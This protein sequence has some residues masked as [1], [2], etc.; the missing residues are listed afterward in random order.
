METPT[1][2]KCPECGSTRVFHDGFRKAPLNALSNEPIQRYRCVD[3]SHRFSYSEQTSNNKLIPFDTSQQNNPC[4][5][6]DLLA[7][8]QK[9]KI[10]VEKERTPTENELKAWLEIEKFLVQLKNDG[11]KAGT[12]LNYRKTFKHLLKDGADLFDPESTKAALAKSTLRESTKK[13]VTGILGNWFEYNQ[14]SWRVPKYS[15]EHEVPYIPTEKELELL[16]AALGKKT[17]CFCQLLKDTGARC[18]EIAELDWLSIDWEQKKVRIKAEKGSNSRIRPLS[19]KTIEML[20]R[21]PRT[22]RNPKRKTKI[23]ANADD[24]RTNFFLQKR[25]IVERQA[26]PKLMLIH[27]HT[28]R[29]WVATTEQHKTKDP[30]HVKL[31][32]GH[33]SIKSTENYI[34]LEKMLYDGD[35][36]DQFT[37]K[38]ADTLEEAIKLMEVGFEFHAEVEDHKLFRKR[39]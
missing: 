6:I 10:C 23:F 14:I 38:V 1:V 9:L 7:H 20:A 33:K 19:T 5:E 24:M 18:G 11:R 22:N 2:I 36:N 28:F 12:I 34:H 21:L 3:Y 32:L 26:N 31:V 13:T 30:W 15:D 37:V 16:I 35:A 17:A 27:F 39:K 25:R 29:H 8:T 4:K